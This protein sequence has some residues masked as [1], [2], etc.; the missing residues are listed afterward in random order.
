MKHVLFL[1]LLLGFIASAFGD[2]IQD[3]Q[4]VSF[5]GQ[6]NGSQHALDIGIDVSGVQIDPRTRTWTLGTTTDFS[7]IQTSGTISAL[8]GVFTIPCTGT[9]TVKVNIF[10]SW[11]ASVTFSYSTDNGASYRPVSAIYMDGVSIPISSTTIDGGFSINSA[12]FTNIQLKA[13]SYTSGTIG[14]SANASIGSN[15]NFQAYRLLDSSG[16]T[17]TIGQKAMAASFPVVIASD[18]SPITAAQGLPNTVANAW[19]IIL[20]D[21]VDTANITAASTAAAATD[22]AL[23]VAQSPNHTSLTGNTPG[24]GSVGVASAALVAANSARK[25]LVIHNNSVNTISLG[26]GVTAVLNSG[27][28]LYPGGIFYMD[29]YTFS[30][31]VINAIST[32]ATSAAPYQELQ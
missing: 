12:G 11:V 6:N 22:K 4:G 23:V 29:E 30:T 21:G 8:N 28:V 16:N 14:I 27:I 3:S 13:Q 10:N 18:Q 32:A 25:G 31:A 15:N 7:D 5:T 17:I 20:T 9:N 19:P 24:L 26:I 1:L 2:V